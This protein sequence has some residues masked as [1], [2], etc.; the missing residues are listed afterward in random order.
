MLK[1]R[2]DFLDRLFI[3]SPTLLGLLLFLAFWKRA[4]TPTQAGIFVL[5]L[6]VILVVVVWALTDV[7]SFSLLLVLPLIIFTQPIAHGGGAEISLGDI[8]SLGALAG[9]AGRGLIRP[10]AV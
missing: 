2:G 7:E 8:L 4:A 9:W 10:Q 3:L 1:S 6:G 5:L